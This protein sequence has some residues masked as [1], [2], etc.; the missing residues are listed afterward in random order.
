MVSTLL[1]ALT[2]LKLAFKNPSE[3]ITNIAIIVSASEKKN[4]NL[5]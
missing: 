2:R 1:V 4:N 5:A 3:F